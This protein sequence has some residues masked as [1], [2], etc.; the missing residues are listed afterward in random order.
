MSYILF[1][2]EL[3]KDNLINCLFVQANCSEHYEIYLRITNNTSNNNNGL[4]Y[5]L[6]IGLQHG[7][8]PDSSQQ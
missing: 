7:L 8:L 5:C 1:L 6:T 4:N 2:K 3:F